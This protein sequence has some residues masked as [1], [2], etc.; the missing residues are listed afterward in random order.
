[1]VRS[2]VREA[3]L[4][5]FIARDHEFF[6]AFMTRLGRALDEAFVGRHAQA[7]HEIHQSLYFLYEQNF[8]TPANPQAANQFH[9]FLL[10]VRNDIERAWERS[11]TRRARVKESE[12]PGDATAFS[13]FFKERCAQHRLSRHALFDFLEFKASREELVDFFLHDRALILRFCDLVS[14]AMIGADDEIRGELAANLWDEMGN[15]DPTMRHT[16]LFRRLLSYVGYEPDASTAST[17]NYVGIHDW[18][19]YAGYNLHLFFSLHRRNYFKSVGCL[20]SSEFMDGSQYAKILRGC[21]RVG[22]EDMEQLAYYASHVEID[23]QHGETWLANVLV[24]LVLKY[25]QARSD[26]VLGAEMRLNVTADYYDSI[27]T[28]LAAAPR[29]HRID[30]TPAQDFAQTAEKT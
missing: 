5:G 28:K 29:Q 9:P 23:A 12:V 2:L 17:E 25:P 21:S 13:R 22:L 6:R 3:D 14:L 11:E 16:V 1:M 27:L 24:P 8:A 18:Q 26:I 7:L 19:G 10:R 20:G 4:D 30:R 15:G